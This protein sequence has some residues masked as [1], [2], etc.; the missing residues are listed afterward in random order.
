M[1]IFSSAL[2]VI[3]GQ[4]NGVTAYIDVVSIDGNGILTIVWLDFCYGYRLV[5]TIF[6]NVFASLEQLKC[7]CYRSICRMVEF[8]SV[9]IQGCY[10]TI[11]ERN[12]LSLAWSF[13]AALQFQGVRVVNLITSRTCHK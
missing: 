2:L 1:S 13:L 3:T 9:V 8:A 5:W 6:C 10:L 11:V 12:V 4:T 7:S